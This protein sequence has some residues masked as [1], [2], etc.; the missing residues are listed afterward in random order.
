MRIAWQ[1]ETKEYL[2]GQTLPPYKGAG[3]SQLKELFHNRI[4]PMKHLVISEYGSFVGVRNGLLSVRNADRQEKRYPLNRLSTLSIAR[5]GI[6]FSSDLIEVFRA[7]EGL[8]FFSWILGE[9][10]RRY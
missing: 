9:H 8:S 1:K 6:S 7:L 2:A 10:P 4:M 5:R 3:G